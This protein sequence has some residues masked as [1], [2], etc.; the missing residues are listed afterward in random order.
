VIA[1]SQEA[2]RVPAEEQIRFARPARG[3]AVSRPPSRQFSLGDRG[4]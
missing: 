1:E 2:R 3:D 4:L